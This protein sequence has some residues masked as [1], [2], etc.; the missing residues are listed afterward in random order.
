MIR[1]QIS[2]LLDGTSPAVGGGIL[3]EIESGRSWAL[4][5][6]GF[7]AGAGVALF[8]RLAWAPLY[9]A[10]WSLTGK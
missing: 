4:S 5:S 10:Q 9:H 1:V 3:G 6:F 8:P 7:S 2:L